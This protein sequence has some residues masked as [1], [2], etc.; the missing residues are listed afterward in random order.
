MVQLAWLWLR[1]QPMSALSRWF[2]Q[3][4][5]VNAGR[6]TMT[7][8][9]NRRLKAV[10]NPDSTGKKQVVRADILTRWKPGQSVDY[11]INGN[12]LTGVGNTDIIQHLD[13]NST[14]DESR[15]SILATGP[16]YIIHNVSHHG[17]ATT[18]EMSLD[19]RTYMLNALNKYWSGRKPDAI[20]FSGG[21]ND[22]VGAQ[23]SIYLDYAPAPSGSTGSIR[24]ASQA[25]LRGSRLPTRAFLTFRNRFAG[26]RFSRTAMTMPLG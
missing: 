6:G 18:D 2:H 26:C 4:A 3:R 24:I 8:T 23:L 14:N 11:P 21:G 17:D 1:H 25:L 20:L 12:D 13:P 22:I 9:T 5:E 15:I 16:Q 19:G 10:E 7:T